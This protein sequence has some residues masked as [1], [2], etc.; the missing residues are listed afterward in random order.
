MVDKYFS[1]GN[2]I[3]NFV[4][5]KTIDKVEG[6]IRAYGGTRYLALFGP[7]KRDAIYNRIIHLKSQKS[8]ITYVISLYYAKMKVDSYDLEILKLKN[9]NF[10]AIKILFFKRCRYWEHISI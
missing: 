3:Q 7:E 10:T 9:V 8:N 2:F 4:W 5:W 6:F 1:L